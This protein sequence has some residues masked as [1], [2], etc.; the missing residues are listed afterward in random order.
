MEARIERLIEFCQGIAN[1]ENGGELYQKYLEEIRTVTPKEVMLIQSIQLAQGTKNPTQSQNHIIQP[2]KVPHKMIGYV[3]KL[4][5]VFYKS[6]SAYEWERPEK[7]SFLDFL[8]QENN[9]LKN[10]LESFRPIIKEGNY[11]ENKEEVQHF[12]QEVSLYQEHLLKLENIL[13]PSLEKKE[14]CYQGL[15]VLW[16]LHDATRAV[17]KTIGSEQ[18][19]YKN[20]QKMTELIGDLYFKLFGLIQKQELI[21]FPCA[22]LEFTKEEFEEM[23]RQSMEYGFPYLEKPEFVE[24]NQTAIGYDFAKKIFKTETGQ[25]DLTQLDAILAALPLDLTLVDEQDKVAFFSRPKERLFPRSAAVIGRDVRNCHP[26]DSVHVVE[27]ILESFKNGE[28]EEA[29]FWIQMR[30]K[31]IYIQYIAIRDQAGNYR[32]TLEMTQDITGLR[33]LQG[34]RRLLSWEEKIEGSRT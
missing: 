27:K 30:G 21:L 14:E 10:L 6:L 4:I 32:G 23:K 31:F 24:N 3:D 16:T 2:E 29:S 13:F 12:I 8:M 5:H 33:A 28:K 11:Q 22:A 19:D 25:F 26:A 9:G 15:K 7:D 34:E 18:I 20:E 17:W 1:Q